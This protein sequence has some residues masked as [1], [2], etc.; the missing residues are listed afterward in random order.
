MSN[1]KE[2]GVNIISILQDERPFLKEE[3]LWMKA[4]FEHLR[5]ILQK[6]DRGELDFEPKCPRELLDKQ[7]AN[8]ANILRIYKEIAAIEG[9]ELGF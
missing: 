5:D 8:M 1:P 2:A 7:Y 6:W 3:A 4:H 9:I